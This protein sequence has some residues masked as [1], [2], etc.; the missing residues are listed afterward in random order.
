MQSIENLNFDDPNVQ[1]GFL[2]GF[3]ATAIFTALILGIIEIIALWK[4]FTK[5]GEK[6]WKSLIPIYNL[7]IFFK[8]VGMKGWFWITLCASI[9]LGCVY[10]ACN[11]KFD[12]NTGQIIGEL[13]TAAIVTTIIVSIVEVVAAI[14]QSLRLATAFGKSTAFAVGLIFLTPI[15]TCILGFDKSKYDK[16]ILKA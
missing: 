8:I 14:K 1:A 2:G 5:A 10:A 6:G 15:F 12:A 13:P 3:F 11:V 7:Y 4:I 16:K 9:V